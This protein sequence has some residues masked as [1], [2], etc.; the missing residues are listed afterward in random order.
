MPGNRKRMRN[1]CQYFQ[2][3][4]VC[5]VFYELDKILCC[6]TGNAVLIINLGMVCTEDKYKIVAGIIA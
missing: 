2:N 4:Q 1:L 5:H 6:F 3:R